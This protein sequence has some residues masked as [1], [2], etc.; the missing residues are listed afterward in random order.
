MSV[1]PKPLKLIC[2]V[3][4]KQ[5]DLVQ[6][7]FHWSASFIWSHEKKDVIYD[8]PGIEWRVSPIVAPGITAEIQIDSLPCVCFQIAQVNVAIILHCRVKDLHGHTLGPRE[9]IAKP[10]LS[11]RAHRFDRV[12]R[13]A[14]QL[15]LAILSWDCPG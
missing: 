7:K 15:A 6:Q 13:Q 11:A 8:V 4:I 12:D 14:Q 10:E 1:S 2:R 5:H 3:S 9:M